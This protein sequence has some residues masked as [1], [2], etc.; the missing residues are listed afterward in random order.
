MESLRFL[1]SRVILCTLSL[2]IT[3][4]S[5]P[6]T[7]CE[8]T[9][10]QLMSSDAAV[11]ASSLARVRADAAL[12]ATARSCEMSPAFAGIMLLRAKDFA[13]GVP[14]LHQAVREQ[15]HDWVSASFLGASYEMMARK[16]AVQ[17]N[18][19][20][21]MAY[22]E[23]LAAAIRFFQRALAS[24]TQSQAISS[25][26][27]PQDAF[28]QPLTLLYRSLGTCL[29]WAGRTAEAR[30]VFAS[31]AAAV[32]WTSPWCRPNQPHH[33]APAMWSEGPIFGSGAP[34]RRGTL[35]SL[36]TS[37]EAAIPAIRDE[38][39][40]VL[41][42]A[43]KVCCVC[44]GRG[45]GEGGSAVDAVVE[46]GSSRPALL[47]CAGLHCSRDPAWAICPSC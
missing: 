39:R 21:T 15:P 7:A 2:A 27:L 18:S 9:V 38:F 20:E 14:L 35:E 12:R 29:L 40:A 24:R 44:I 28:S 16:I 42:Q 11:R 10:R 19:S 1:L 47:P 32:G 37:F 6:R 5:D 23:A 8:G 3:F 13:G 26:P 30:A 45:G 33:Q 22:T 46:M 41:L 4:A 17:S 36:L 31:G 25:A 43:R 34:G